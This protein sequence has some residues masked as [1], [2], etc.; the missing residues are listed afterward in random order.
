MMNN[1]KTDTGDRVIK[2]QFT[3]NHIVPLAWI[4][5]SL[6]IVT[7]FAVF[8]IGNT[9]ASLYLMVGIICLVFIFTIS[10]TTVLDMAK[11]RIVL[12]KDSF[13]YHGIGH[14]IFPVP[15]TR[16]IPLREIK[17]IKMSSGK[18]F[19]HLRVETTNQDSIKIDV[20]SFSPHDL[21]QNLED[22]ILSHAEANPP[23]KQND[24]TV[25][26]D[27]LKPYMQKGKLSVNGQKVTIDTEKYIIQTVVR[28]GDVVSFYY[29]RLF[30][31]IWSI[32]RFNEPWRTNAIIEI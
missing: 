14:T 18:N 21:F 11:A 17:R 31:Y 4:I 7:A 15:K 23:E 20:S 22:W 12:T 26:L 32:N 2:A 19:Y 16:T 8:G 30:A 13:C 3:I 6:E 1:S 25:Y 24:I 10:L 28:T 9:V 27:K 29:S 5:L